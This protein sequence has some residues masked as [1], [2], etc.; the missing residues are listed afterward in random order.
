VVALVIGNLTAHLDLLFLLVL[1]QHHINVLHLNKQHYM[2]ISLE[3][4][5]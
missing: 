3:D 4:V 2:S 5:E 1:V